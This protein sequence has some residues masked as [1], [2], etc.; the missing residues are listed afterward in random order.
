M[1]SEPSFPLEAIRLKNACSYTYLNSLYLE[2]WLTRFQRE[3]EKRPRPA[4]Y[5]ISLYDHCFYSQPRFHDAEKE[6]PTIYRSAGDNPF[7]GQ[8]VYLGNTPPGSPLK[9][10]RFTIHGY[11]KEVNELT[12]TPTGETLFSFLE[13]PMLLWPKSQVFLFPPRHQQIKDRL[14][15]TL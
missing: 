11:W 8:N 2:R 3:H 1:K 15:P 12:D 9:G 13:S 6:Y 5:W 14:L 10:M 4:D 7:A